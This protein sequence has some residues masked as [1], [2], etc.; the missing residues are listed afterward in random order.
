MGSGS[1]VTKQ[2]G[3]MILTDDNFGTLVHAVEIGRRVYEK[4]VAYVRY[5][6]TQLLALVL[7]FV[8]ASAFDINSGVV[9]TPSMVLYLLF[10]A[11]AIG[12]VVIAVDPGDPD[13]MHRPPRDPKVPITNRG[14][15]LTWLLYAAVLFVAALI[16]LVAGPDTPHPN[17]ASASMTMTFVVMGLGTSLNAVTNRRDPASGLNPPLLKAVGISLFSVVMIVLATQLPTIQSG[18]LTQ[19][20]SGREWLACIGLA[21]LLPLVIEGKKWWYRRSAAAPPPISVPDAVAPPSAASQA[22]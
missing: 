2:A 15:I 19:S 9:L 17:Q 11:T 22:G 3:R 6:M 1:E 7:L 20:L 16:P 10:F 21:L 8:V 18:L 4:V 5:Q 14:A 13:V 12:V